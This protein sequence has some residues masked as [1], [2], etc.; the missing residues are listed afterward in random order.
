VALNIRCLRQS[1]SADYAEE[2]GYDCNDKQ[3][4]YQT[5]GMKSDKSNGPTDDE[6]D[7]NDVQQVSHGIVFFKL[8][9]LYVKII[10][11]L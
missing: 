4:V 7:S 1:T 6:D 9:Y 10:A 11:C 8:V 5:S 2:N 3:N